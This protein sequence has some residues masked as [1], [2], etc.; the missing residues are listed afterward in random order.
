M[1]ALPELLAAKSV[2]DG[3]RADFDAR[4]ATVRGDVAARSVGGRVTDS[5]IEAAQDVMDEAVA[6]ADANRGIVAG[7]LAVLA[8][9]FLRNPLLALG[10]H[11]LDRAGVSDDWKDY[12]S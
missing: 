1:T 8:L 12:L 2:R 11:L 7:T 10:S 4:L 9:W 5:A 3:A 6:V